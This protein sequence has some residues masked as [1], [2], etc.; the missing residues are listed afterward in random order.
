M[1]H[2]LSKLKQSSLEV[3]S[4]MSSTIIFSVLTSFIMLGV[5]A[6]V[7]NAPSYQQLTDQGASI[8]NL[9]KYLMRRA[10]IPYGPRWQDMIGNSSNNGDGTGY[11]QGLFFCDRLAMFDFMSALKS[12]VSNI[13]FIDN[14]T[15]HMN[16]TMDSI[17]RLWVC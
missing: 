15:R 5:S 12:N 14:F 6:S 1:C 3:L 17:C 7:Y 11:G 2:S 9:A 16:V 8:T 13:T 10:D 4:T